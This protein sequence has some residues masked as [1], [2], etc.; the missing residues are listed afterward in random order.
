[1]ERAYPQRSCTGCRQ[2]K[3]K[4]DLIRIVRTPDGQFHVDPGGKANGRGAYVCPSENCIRAAFQRGSLSKSLKAP[5]PE[6]LLETI[7]KELKTLE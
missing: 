7:L 2:I 6:D 4:R 1:M 5:V 3:N